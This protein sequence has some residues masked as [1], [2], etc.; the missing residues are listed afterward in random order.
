MNIQ[1]TSLTFTYPSGVTALRDV[2][3][4][5]SSGES[6][7]IIGQ[8]GAGKTTLVKHLN[9]LLKPTSGSARVGEWDTREHSVAKLA[10][11]V[12]YV[13]QNPDEQLFQQTLRAEVMFGPKNLGWGVEK[14]EAQTEAA[15]AMVG[16]SEA[17]G[18]HPYDLSPGERK[19]AALAAVLAM[20]TPIVVFDEPTTGQDD[21]G[22]A[23]VGNIVDDLHARGKTVITITHDIDFCAEHFERVA[24]MA[25]GRILLDGPGRDVLAQAETLARAYVDPPQLVRLAQRLG[26]R[27]TPL[28]VEEFV[29]AVDPTAE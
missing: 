23:L 1:I 5:I 13:F 17:A 11:R 29:R 21:A 9:G 12:G 27:A 14:V 28:R 24:V 10:A 18:R 25:E 3:L 8:N 20:D 26:M 16:L 2:S 7:A 19:R 6:V 15:L 4:S 22:V